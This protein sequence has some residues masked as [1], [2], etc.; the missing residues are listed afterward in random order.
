VHPRCRHRLLQVTCIACA[1]RFEENGAK[2]CVQAVFTKCAAGKSPTYLIVCRTADALTPAP[3]PCVFCVARAQVWYCSVECQKT[4]WTEG[5]HKKQCK[6]LQAVMNAEV[7]VHGGVHAMKHTS[8]TPI[9]TSQHI[10]FTAEKRSAATSRRTH[11]ATASA[12]DD[13]VCIIC[14]DDDSPPIQSGCACR[15]NAG[16]AHVECRQR[17]L[18]TAWQTVIHTKG[19]GKTGRVGKDLPGPWSWD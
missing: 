7:A 19:G 16:L 6:A 18:C 10:A 5:G 11:V 14:L 15:G 13:G 12:S 3:P 9:C 8:S 17:T 2:Q 1:Q 4:H